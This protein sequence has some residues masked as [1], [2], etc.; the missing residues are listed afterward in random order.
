MRLKEIEVYKFQELSEKA[1]NKFRDSEL[2]IGYFRCD[3]AINSIKKLA[4]HFNSELKNYSIDFLDGYRNEYLIDVPSYMEDVTEEELKSLV[5][6]LG[7]YNKDTFKGLG[8][9][10]LAG[11]CFDEDAIDG[12]RIAYF[13]GIRDIKTL[14]ERAFDSWY[15]SANADAEYQISDEGLTELCE[16]NEYE[17]L[18]NGD[19]I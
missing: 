11:V 4:E 6:S 18:S 5:D 3:E 19:L 9:C 15:K 8:D 1:K 2:E 7:K 10:V 16:A 14:L 17:F 12:L 13:N